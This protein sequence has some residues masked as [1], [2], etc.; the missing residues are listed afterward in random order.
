MNSLATEMY[1]PQKRTWLKVMRAERDLTQT[2]TAKLCGISQMEYSYI[3][4]GRMV[5]TKE[6]A[7]AIGEFFGFDWTRFYEEK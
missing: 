6:E 2:M 5:P 3:E 1:E 4:S 7:K